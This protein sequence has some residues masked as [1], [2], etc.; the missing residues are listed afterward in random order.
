VKVTVAFPQEVKQDFLKRNHE[1]RPGAE[2]RARIKCGN[3][4]LAYVLFRD[5]VQFWHEKILFRWPFI[6]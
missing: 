4:R 6:H 1:L 2:V 3:A 5:V